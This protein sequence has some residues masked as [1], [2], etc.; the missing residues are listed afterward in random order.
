MLRNLIII[1]VISVTLSSCFEKDEMVPTH[2]PGD[3]VTATIPMTMF[4]TYQAY[5]SLSTSEITSINDRSD[6]DLNFECLDTS[7]VIRL[8]TANFAMAAITDHNN[9]LDIIDTV[10]LV[11]NFDGSTGSIDSLAINNWITVLS[12]D[13]TYADKV[14]IFNRGI[15][16]LGVQLGLM[17]IKF[18]EFKDGAYYFTYAQMDNS[19]L[20]NAVVEKD[21]LHLFKQYSFIG[22]TAEQ[23]EPIATNWDLLFTQYTSLLYTTEG[24]AYPYL[25][26]GVLSQYDNLS[27]ALDTNLV[28]ND[29]TI[30][31]TVTLEF[32]KNFD[33][34]G[35]NWKELIGDINTGDIRYEVRTNYNYIIKDS[36]SYFYKLRFVNFYD[37]VTGEKGFP[38]FEYQRL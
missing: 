16:S 11:W 25:V 37:P 35:Y 29:I 5:Y 23:F 1:I 27:V 36:K 28:F 21:D 31:D 32:S 4:Y 18:T 19:N 2:I 12:G 17:K 15:N 20:V 10:G 6:F 33:K 30:A 7:T 14:W 22:D 38:T 13:T 26:T 9:I 24:E 34:I 8:N 3:V